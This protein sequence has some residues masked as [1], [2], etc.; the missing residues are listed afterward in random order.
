[1]DGETLEE[2]LVEADGEILA[3]IEELGLL[4]A[5]EED[6]GERERLALDDGE[7]PGPIGPG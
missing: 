5:D 3:L 6:D 1:M 4:L 7:M 2:G